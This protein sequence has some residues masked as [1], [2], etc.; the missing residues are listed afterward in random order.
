[1]NNKDRSRTAFFAPAACTLPTVQQPLRVREWD[2]L[3]ATGTLRVDRPDPHHAVFD[4]HPDPK[5]AGRAADLAIRESQCCSLFRF[6]LFASGGRLV[7]DVSV[8]T[9][10]VEILDALVGQA[11]AATGSRLR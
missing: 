8:Q 3:F 6:S 4:L 7:L 5:N 1:M 2:E 10:Q 11:H 9:A